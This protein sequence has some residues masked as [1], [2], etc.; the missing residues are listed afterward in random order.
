MAIVQ[1][2]GQKFSKKSTDISVPAISRPV[3]NQVGNAWNGAADIDAYNPETLYFH[4][5]GNAPDTTTLY[6]YGERLSQLFYSELAQHDH[7][8]GSLATGNVSSGSTNH[9]HPVTGGITNSSHSHSLITEDVGVVSLKGFV[10][11]P[12]GVSTGGLVVAND[13]HTH[14]HSLGTSLNN[15]D[16]HSHLVASGVTSGSGNAPDAGPVRTGGGAK[17][18]FDDMTITID[19]VDQTS[20][21]QAQAGVVKFGD[22][23]SGHPLVTLGIELDLSGII[24]TPGQHKIVFSVTGNDNGGKIRYNLYTFE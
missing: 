11:S 13:N 2:K 6:I 18:Y 23:T 22:G 8:P 5:F 14:A 1:G 15:V 16:A 21:L 9:S 10:G 12:A 19:G 4:V 24:L 17:T 3:I 7:G 20:A